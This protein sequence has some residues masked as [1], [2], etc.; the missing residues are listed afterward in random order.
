M[1]KP[2][3]DS[4]RTFANHYILS[5]GGMSTIHLHE[6][7]KK[8]RNKLSPIDVNRPIMS[9]NIKYTTISTIRKEKILKIK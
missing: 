8:R 3:F 2:P 6:S 7:K 9:Y 5:I 1:E 4:K